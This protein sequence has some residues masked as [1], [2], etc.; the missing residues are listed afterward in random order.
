M[1][2]FSNIKNII[3]HV[4]MQS[5]SVTSLIVIM[6]SC[7]GVQMVRVIVQE[8]IDKLVNVCGSNRLSTQFTG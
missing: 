4:D 7:F 3:F 5:R 6:I 2:T 8:D 1:G